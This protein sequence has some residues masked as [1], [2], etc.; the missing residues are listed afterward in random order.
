MI[1][2]VL[3]NFLDSR[4]STRSLA[5]SLARSLLDYTLSL[6]CKRGDDPM[7][8]AMESSL[9]RTTEDHNMATTTTTIFSHFEWSVLYK[10][11]TMFYFS[12]RRPFIAVPQRNKR[13]TL[14]AW[15][16]G[17]IIIIT[18]LSIILSYHTIQ[19]CR[20]IIHSHPPSIQSFGTNLHEDPDQNTTPPQSN[21]VVAH[22]TTKNISS[23]SILDGPLAGL[24]PDYQQSHS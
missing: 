1:A 23:S 6:N 12:G 21:D 5:Y 3:L 16:L 24:A 8:N 17:I 20:N 2:I 11:L 13:A 9:G 22:T 15:T 7:E 18:I 14:G 10:T 19:S 4:D